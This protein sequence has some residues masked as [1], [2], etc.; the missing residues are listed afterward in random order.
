V[1]LCLVIKEQYWEEEG[2]KEN[3]GGEW[4]QVWYIWYIVGTFVNATMYPHPA[5]Q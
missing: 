2:I 3:G 1:G 5:Q 4:I